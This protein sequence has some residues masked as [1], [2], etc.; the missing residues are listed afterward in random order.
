MPVTIEI[1]NK[2]E[3]PDRFEMQVEGIDPDW[4]AIPEPVFQVGAGEINSQKAFI[5]APRASESNAGNY[6]FVVRVRSLESGEART[7]QG[8]YQLKAFHHLSMELS[9]K[10]GFISP[11]RHNNV[12]GVT[13][14]NL[15]NTE[16]TLQLSGADPEEVCTF[17]FTQSEVSIG[18]GQ[19]KVVE[20]VVNAARP[21]LI[22][23]SQL[24]GFVINARSIQTPSVS[25]NTQ[26][27]LEQ[28][29]AL[30][31]ASLAL[32]VFLVAL[33]ALWFAFRPQ[34]PTMRLS[35]EKAS[36]SS[37]QT[38]KIHWSATNASSV[39]L[40]IKRSPDGKPDQATDEVFEDQ[41]LTGEK[42]IVATDAG[43]VTVTATA[44][45]ESKQ[46]A[47]NPVT[48]NVLPPPVVAPPKILKFQASSSRVKL[49]QPVVF[50]FSF[51]DDVDHAV[52][53]PTNEQIM[54]AV[55]QI[56]VMPTRTGDITY[57]LIAYNKAGGQASRKLTVNIYQASDATILSFK[58]DPATI[59][60][61]NDLTLV[62]W[63]VT[64]ASLVQLDDGLGNTRT[65]EASNTDG[66]EVRTDKNIQLKLIATDAKGVT[67]SKTLQVKYKPLPPTDVPPTTTGTDAGA[68]TTGGLR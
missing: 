18:P 36:V 43:T 68:A 47:S 4:V 28:R 31:I 48:I 21:S 16:H 38:T 35:A 58:A 17:E 20:V 61:P 51:S 55:T 25:A 40:V 12:F 53:A 54:P 52:L 1:V 59:E 30:T 9:P 8:V 63:Q 15:S 19:Q 65:V 33:A 46:A 14:M 2:G 7:V 62:T 23:T 5:K 57:E 67:V 32:I 39:K 6:P 56:E 11:T 49:G 34:P 60:A 64:N 24:Y 22:S 26:G 27:Q 29:P 66:L 42:E 3:A 37:G 44:I 41:P 13:I 45:G 50:T 10:K